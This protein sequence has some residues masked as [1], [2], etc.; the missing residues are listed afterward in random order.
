MKFIVFSDTHSCNYK[1][2]AKY[3][4]GVNSRLQNVLSAIK[5]IQSEG[6]RLDVDFYLF[7]GDLFHTQGYVEN[8]VFNLTFDAFKSFDKPVICV[9]GNHDTFH[10]MASKDLSFSKFEEIPNVSIYT[11]GEQKSISGIDIYCYGYDKNL[12][13]EKIVKNI[14]DYGNLT[15]FKIA[16]I[17]QTPKGCKLNDYVFD[18]GIE[19]K[20]IENVANLVLFGHIHQPQKLSE[21]SLVI[22]S[23]IQAN[24]GDKGDRGFWLFDV[25][26]KQIQTS[27]H[28]IDLPHFITADRITDEIKRDTKNYYRILHLDSNERNDNTIEFKQAKDSISDRNIVDSAMSIES[29][30]DRYTSYQKI[31]TE[32]INKYRQY[33]I[34]LLQKADKEFQPI[35]P[36]N[37]KLEKVS[38]EGFLSF[39][40]KVELKIESG[41]WLI[42]GDC[43]VFTSNGAGKTTV[44]DSIFWCLYNQTTKGISANNVINDESDKNCRVILELLDSK[45]N[46]KLVIDRYRK[47]DKIGTG[48]TIL[49]NDKEI[50][51][52]ASILEKKLISILGFDYDFFLNTVYYS[53]EK[54]EFFASS[55]DSV[56]KSFL[57][58]ILQTAK[59][60][61]ALKYCRQ[62]LLSNEKDIQ[63]YSI[64]NDSLATQIVKIEESI[65]DLK[66]K[67]ELYEIDRLNKIKENED[68]LL[69]VNSLILELEQ[70]KKE[71]QVE[72]KSNSIDLM[73]LTSS[74]NK[75]NTEYLNKKNEIRVIISSVSQENKIFNSDIE[76]NKQK[77][78]RI[79][80]LQENN[81]CS[82]CGNIITDNSKHNLISELEAI[83]G[84]ST[85]VIKKNEGKLNILQEE[86]SLIDSEYKQK[87]D[88]FLSQKS[89]VELQVSSLE[90]E[91]DVLDG[92]LNK[93]ILQKNS[94][95]KE[96]YRKR[97][98]T[99]T[100]I[101][102]IEVN[103]K[104]IK[105]KQEEIETNKSKSE[106]L[107][108]VK[109]I[110]S[111]WEVGFSNKGIKSLLFDEF[112]RLFNNE[113]GNSLSLLSSNS[114]SVV[115]NNQTRLASGELSERMSIKVTLFG[116][117]KDYVNLSGGEKRRV[118]IA[119]MI[120]L[121]KIIRQMYNISSG[122]LGILILDEIFSSLD[123]S[124]EET[125][126]DLLEELTQS[127]N[128][129]YVIT[130]TDE[131]KSF[132]NNSI[133]VKKRNRCSFIESGNLEKK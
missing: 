90:N 73:T 131:L 105:S 98:E 120:T 121:N 42:L 3:T 61:I 91:L 58:S 37:Y 126:Y 65:Q 62:E 87:I 82:N 100:F 118:D 26:N 130:H 77:I 18:D 2:F 46:T 74:Q 66:R 104:S 128:S 111:F 107:L 85:K 56:K 110:I 5:T 49:Q 39:K 52:T 127:I 96:L 68:L 133:T 9:P 117:E 75:I 59:Y 79:S 80:N 22:G 101:T 4:D 17:H 125:V 64:L 83:I 103:T 34:D 92:K 99:N 63:K 47:Y 25:N 78:Y 51:G 69:V 24:F 20:E 93:N 7:G 113:I 31:E 124:G 97:N 16:I 48:L 86:L 116:K 114:M 72:L 19:Y 55:T 53:Q 94:L 71:K 67:A 57:D 1:S 28:S 123:D 108:S 15:D 35:I 11:D 13:T 115:L 33:G 106:L 129:I 44:F 88:G 40:D 89:K 76:S 102:E 10:S 54:T 70:D 27:F 43:D 8:D 12:T 112:C 81:L 132:F 41:V 32:D 23:P 38:I 30:V 122:L 60:D 109:K 29:V 36:S 50:E 21:K 119:I 84:N 95:E 6:K 45:T 14:Q